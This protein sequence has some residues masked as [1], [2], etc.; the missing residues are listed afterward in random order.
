MDFQRLILFVIFSMS[1]VFLF[2]AWQKENAPP[3]PPKA[4]APVTAPAE[5]KS[6]VPTAVPSATTTPGATASGSVPATAGAVPSAAAPAASAGDVFTVKTDLF[7]AKINTLGGVI[8]EVALKEH[9]DGADKSKPY[10]VLMK[11]KDRTHVA[12]SGLI[13]TGLPNHN[14]PYSKVSSST[15]MGS[16]DALEVRLSAPNGQGGK[17]DLV[18]TFKRGSYIVDVGYDVTNGSDVAITPTAYFHLHRDTKGS[19]S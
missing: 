4:V 16:A 14:T 3:A 7:E 19:G 6:D 11:T 8:E 10:L 12:Q 2:Q 1:G 5:K 17:T 9:R 15:D 13:G 18:Y